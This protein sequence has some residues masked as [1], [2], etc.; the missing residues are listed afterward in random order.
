VPA[1][2]ANVAHELAQ[3]H[4][5]LHASRRPSHPTFTYLVRAR[6]SPQPAWGVCTAVAAQ[7][8]LGPGMVP[9]D[10]SKHSN[11]YGSVGGS[12]QSTRKKRIPKKM[13]VGY[14]GLVAYRRHEPSSDVRFRDGLS[15]TTGASK[16]HPLSRFAVDD[17]FEQK[18]DDFRRA[19]WFDTNQSD[20]RSK[21]KFPGYVPTHARAGAH[22]THELAKSPASRPG[23]LMSAV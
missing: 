2:G 15:K 17:E 16:V 3:Q 9:I 18:E 1:G 20:T 21:L 19:P 6:S 22:G 7:S 4:R 5:L 8:H 14:P 23:R 12:N 10:T 13:A 11:S